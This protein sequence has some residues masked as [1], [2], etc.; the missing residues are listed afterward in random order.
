MIHHKTV[1][2]KDN[3]IIESINDT[4]VKVCMPLKLVAL[5]GTP[6][7]FERIKKDFQ[8]RGNT[9]IQS[10]LDIKNDKV[11]VYFEE[12]VQNKWLK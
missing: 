11:Y 9:Y 5:K 3:V 6:D 10:N 4:K 7:I 8:F 2:Y 12:Q 1:T